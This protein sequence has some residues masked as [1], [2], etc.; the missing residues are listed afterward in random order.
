MYENCYTFER[1][2]WLGLLFFLEFRKFLLST[3]F[4]NRAFYI[5]LYKTL[6]VFCSGA[7][8]VIVGEI[9]RLSILN[10]VSLFTIGFLLIC[11]IIVLIMFVLFCIALKRKLT[12]T[13]KS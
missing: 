1:C 9:Y 12:W 13:W 5:W 6:S 3:H 11:S 4:T 8:A 10:S 2:F 7:F